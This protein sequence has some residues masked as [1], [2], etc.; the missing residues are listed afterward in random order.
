MLQELGVLPPRPEVCS[1]RIKKQ[2]DTFDSESLKLIVPYIHMLQNT[3][4]ADSTVMDHIYSLKNFIF[5]CKDNN[6]KLS[7]LTVNENTIRAYLIILYKNKYNLKYLRDTLGHIKCF[8]KYVKYKKLVLFNPAKNINTSREAE[9]LCVCSEEQIEKLFSY[10][11]N[12]NS[13]PEYALLISLILVW[14][15]KNEDLANAK[16][17]VNDSTLSIILRQKKLT[18]GKRYYNREGILKLPQSPIWF[19]NL[20]KRFYKNWIKNYEKTK[21]SFPNYSVFLPY[22]F[23]HNR[24]LSNETINKRSLLATKEATGVAVPIKILRQTCGFIHSRNGDAS[25]LSTLGWS[26]EFS[27]AY[28]WLPVTYYKK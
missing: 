8:Y 15:L 2:L 23:V 19:Y 26:Q 27:F 20:Q 21:K 9:K 3:K 4:R 24:P 10:I 17:S 14:G 12:P 16:L 5:W 13:N 18:K 1:H 11:K 28:T 22:S 25:I 6:D 7:L